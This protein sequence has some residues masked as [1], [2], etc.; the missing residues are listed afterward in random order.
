MPKSALV[1]QTFD[2]EIFGLPFYRVADPGSPSLA[3]EIANLAAAGRFAVD[4]KLSAGDTEGLARLEALG[5]RR[6]CGQTLLT[7]DL[8]GPD[9]PRGGIAARILDRL[10]LDAETLRAHAAGFRFA[11]F[12]QDPRLPAAGAQR[13]LERWIANSLG[14]RC[15]LAVIGRDFCSFRAAGDEIVIDL[16]SCLETGQ[17]H[18]SALLQAVIAHGRARAARSIRVVT[19]SE[20]APALRAYERNGFRRCGALVVLH[21]VAEAGQPAEALP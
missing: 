20:N 4:A 5:F 10:E 6:V 3:G 9:A 7:H 17:G 19:E 13:L 18:A 8:A 12:L 1:Y 21:L 16:L 15:K 14:G 11:R 2:S